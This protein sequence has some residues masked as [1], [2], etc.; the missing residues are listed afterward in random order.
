MLG[1]IWL[2]IS[3][4]KGK[5]WASRPIQIML[6]LIAIGLG[7]TLMMVIMEEGEQNLVEWI[8]D[9]SLTLMVVAP[10]ISTAFLVGMVKSSN[11]E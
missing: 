1:L 3:Y 6:L 9:L 7:C 4:A 11:T 5:S 2:A 8:F 10:V